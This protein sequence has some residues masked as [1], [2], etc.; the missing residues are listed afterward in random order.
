MSNSHEMF[1]LDV[2]TIGSVIA[3]HIADDPFFSN[4]LEKSFYLWRRSCLSKSIGKLLVGIG[5]TDQLHMD[6]I[7]RKY[8]IQLNQKY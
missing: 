6:V 7:H 1:P 5:N 4:A 2:S 3:G 8:I